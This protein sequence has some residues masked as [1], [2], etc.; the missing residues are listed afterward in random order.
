MSS[1]YNTEQ[2]DEYGDLK[3]IITELLSFKDANGYTAV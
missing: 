1:K 2:Y 3:E